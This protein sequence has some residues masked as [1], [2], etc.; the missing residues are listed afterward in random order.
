MTI[1]PLTRMSDIAPAELPAYEEL[2]RELRE[3]EVF[4]T[5]NGLLSWDQE[6]MMPIAGTSLRAEQ[7]ATLS[8]LVHQRRTSERF[9]EL[10]TRSEQEAALHRDPDV[11]VNLREI[12]RDYERAVRIP[13]SLVREFA[14]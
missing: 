8:Q 3:T 10:L 14:E 11:L 12:R 13:T 9:A 7:S 5:I 6:V 4:S 2:R 1:T